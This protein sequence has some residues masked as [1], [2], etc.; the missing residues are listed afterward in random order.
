MVR[1]V[2]PRLSRARKGVAAGAARLTKETLR[3]SGCMVE[4]NAALASVPYPRTMRERLGLIGPKR[5]MY[6]P[7]LT[8]ADSQVKTLLGYSTDYANHRVPTVERVMPVVEAAESKRALDEWNREHSAR[9]RRVRDSA[10]VTPKPNAALFDMRHLMTDA[11]WAAAPRSPPA[12]VS[13]AWSPPRGGALTDLVGLGDG[14]ADEASCRHWIRQSRKFEGEV[15]LRD[16]ELTGRVPPHTY[17]MGFKRG[18]TPAL[19]EQRAAVDEFN[20]QLVCAR[21]ARPA[22]ASADERFFVES[23]HAAWSGVTPKVNCLG[24]DGWCET[25]FN[26]RRTPSRGA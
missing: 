13:A 7:Q 20:R 22:T 26:A 11:K 15:G 4:D 18:S 6:P 23:H 14:D 5:S 16:C 8:G 19:W 12:S 24:W 25:T 1:T 3:G 17:D 2:S 9:V 21:A 10:G